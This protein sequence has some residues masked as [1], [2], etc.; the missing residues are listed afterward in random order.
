MGGA[1]IWICMLRRGRHDALWV[2]ESCF[3]S[4]PLLP[5]SFPFSPSRTGKIHDGVV[6]RV[7]GA[8][9]GFAMF[10]LVLLY[11]RVDM[12]RAEEGEYQLKCLLS[13]L[14]R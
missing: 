14:Y 12:R 7:A 11:S 8:G 10:F 4:F 13:V 3:V 1:G 6:G 2:S 9:W 5:F